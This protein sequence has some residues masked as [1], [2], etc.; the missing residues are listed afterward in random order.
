MSA[1]RGGSQLQLLLNLRRGEGLE[2]FYDFAGRGVGGRYRHARFFPLWGRDSISLRRTEP[3]WWSPILSAVPLERWLLTPPETMPSPN[4][5][6]E[7]TKFAQKPRASRP[8]SAQI[9][10]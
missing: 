7:F 8:W 6:P 1:E 3:R 2:S 10:S 4:Y 5:N 9:S